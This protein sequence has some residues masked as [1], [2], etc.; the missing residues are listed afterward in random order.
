MRPEANSGALLQSCPA[1]GVEV[2]TRFVP[3]TATQVF[4][5][6]SVP[7][8][9][10]TTELITGPPPPATPAACVMFVALAT[11]MPLPPMEIVAAR[12]ELEV[13]AA[14][15]SAT[16]MGPAPEVALAVIQLCTPERVQGQDA[17]VVTE[18]LRLLAV[19]WTCAASG[20]S[21]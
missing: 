19:A 15:E 8:Y 9:T 1:A 12:L 18:R 10:V 16:V 2:G 7:A 3:L 17:A 14:I 6:M 13:F 5:E 20:E 21:V 11:R 4:C